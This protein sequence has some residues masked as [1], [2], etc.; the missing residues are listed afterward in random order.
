VFVV[1]SSLFLLMRGWW[2]LEAHSSKQSD[3]FSKTAASHEVV[4]LSREKQTKWKAF[5]LL[6]LKRRFALLILLGFGAWRMCK[7]GFPQSIFFIIFQFLIF[8]SDFYFFIFLIFW[9]FPIFFR[10]FHISIFLPLR[11]CFAFDD[12]FHIFYNFHILALWWY[13][14]CFS[15]FTILLHILV[16]IKIFVFV[17]ISSLILS[18]FRI[19]A[20]VW[21]QNQSG[22]FLRNLP[23]SQSLFYYCFRY[24]ELIPAATAFHKYW[25]SIY[26]KKRKSWERTTRQA[27]KN[28]KAVPLKRL[29]LAHQWKN[30][31]HVS[32][33]APNVIVRLYWI[34]WFVPKQ[35]RNLK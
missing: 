8:L 1:K 6:V 33:W 17:F 23:R 24:E 13:F 35:E 26:W 29:C 32:L 19:I 3:W 31:T 21:K 4:S 25:Y 14:Q 2:K 15:C 34:V 11:F 18:C 9:S 30:R 10:I 12:I 28:S 22:R 20:I 16:F 7:W 27:R 5:I